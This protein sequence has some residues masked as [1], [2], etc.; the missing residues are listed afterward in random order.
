MS[1][2]LSVNGI[3]NDEE[4]VLGMAVPL[5]VTLAMILTVIA[6]FTLKAPK[7][8]FMP[9]VLWLTIKHGIFV[10]G[11][12][13]AGAVMWQ[14]TMGTISVSLAT[15]VLV[16]SLIAGLVAGIVNYMTIR[17]SLIRPA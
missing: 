15:A 13:V 17:A 12:C 8:R 5:A 10:F 4:T 11:L 1:I 14:R 16:L 6:Y 7:K 3:A 2:P 9:Q